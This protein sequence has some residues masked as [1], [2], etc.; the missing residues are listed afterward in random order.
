MGH[1]EASE[2]T[3]AGKR[4]PELRDTWQRRSAPQQGGE[5]Q[6]H[7]TRGSAGAHLDRE[8]R[9][10]AAGHVAALEPTSV[11]RCGPKLQGT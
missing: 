2:P 8:T 3:S 5:V 11:R 9:S 10:R 4:G 6:R 1:V 7:M